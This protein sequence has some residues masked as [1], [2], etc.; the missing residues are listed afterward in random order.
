MSRLSSE[1]KSQ[2]DCVSTLMAEVH[3]LMSS[4][5]THLRRLVGLSTQ[6]TMQTASAGTM[7]SMHTAKSGRLPVCRQRVQLQR[8]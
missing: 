5:Q 3:F 4:H 1:L 6:M 7:I 8:R 2:T